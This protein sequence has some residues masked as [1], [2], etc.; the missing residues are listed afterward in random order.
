MVR[1]YLNARWLEWVFCW[2]HQ[3]SM[4]FSSFERRIWRATLRGFRVR[5]SEIR[6]R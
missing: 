3:N 6:I 5:S 2:E 1:A 4:V